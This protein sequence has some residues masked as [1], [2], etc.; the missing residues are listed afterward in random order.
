MAGVK[1]VICYLLFVI[2]DSLK[3]DR[4]LVRGN[5]E[6]G[7]PTERR[8]VVGNVSR[9]LVFGESARFFQSEHLISLP[10]FGFLTVEN[11]MK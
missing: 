7:E 10:F 6:L 11:P 4:C 2:R 9:Q 3:R 5:R 1:T 8:D